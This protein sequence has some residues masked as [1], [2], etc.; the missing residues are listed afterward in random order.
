MNI[1][2]L[3]KLTDADGIPGHEYE[4]KEILEKELSGIVDEID[5]D[6]IGSFVSVIKKANAP[7]I[8]LAGHMDEVGFMVSN[9]TDEG[10]VKFRPVGG[11]FDQVLLAKKLRITTR[12]GK[13]FTGVIG[14]KPPHVLPP[15]KRKEVVKIESM[16]IDLGVK[17]KAAVEKMGI[18]KG[19]MITPI[20]DFELMNDPDYFLAKAFDNR[21]G[22]FVMAEVMKNVALKRDELNC[23][24]YGGAT[25]QEE[26]GLRGATTLAYKVNPDIAISLDTGIAGDTPEMTANESSAKLGDGLQLLIMDASAIAHVGLR[27]ALTDLAKEMNIPIQEEILLAGGTDNGRIHISQD[28]VVGISLVVTTRYLH[29]HNSM[30]HRNDVQGLIDL[31][32]EFILKLDSK[33]LEEIKA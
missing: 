28:G 31:I 13:K 29:T 21:V 26:V 16:F 10:F 2:F 27:Y 4:V 5:S 3:K 8:L 24:V 11:W 25:V 14:A 32:T 6:N 1:E 33:M 7:K 30:I 22:C 23:E 12:S 20:G 17:D 15:E 9:I 19:D 18:C